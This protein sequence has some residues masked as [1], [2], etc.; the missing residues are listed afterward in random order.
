MMRES[1]IGWFTITKVLIS[2]IS[3]KLLHIIKLAKRSIDGL[4]S[5][6]L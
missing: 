6:Q 1:Q 3:E 4:L 5:S 2:S